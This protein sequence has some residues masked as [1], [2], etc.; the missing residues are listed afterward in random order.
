[1]GRAGSYNADWRS[2]TPGYFEAM[3]VPLKQGRLLR[4]S[5]HPQSPP[6][7]LIDERMAREVFGSESPG[8]KR[9]RAYRPGFSPQDPWAEIVGGVGHVLNDSLE[10]DARR[11]V[12]WPETQRTQDRAALAVR[13]AG[14][15]ESFTPAV[16][17]Q[18]RK[19]NPDQPVY[20]V[21]SME[22]WVG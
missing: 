22:Q 3:G 19:E 4:E 8:G 6:V 12:Y 18:I 1:E 7:G 14:H 20:D 10:S 2:A 17:E 16:L 13:M 5:D 9:L 15:P 11:Q 21:R